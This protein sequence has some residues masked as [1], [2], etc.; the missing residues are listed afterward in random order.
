MST[1]YS[2]DQAQLRR[3]TESGIA[4][5]RALNERDEQELADLRTTR[6]EYA[7]EIAS[8]DDVMADLNDTISRRQSKMRGDLISQLPPTEGTVSSL[9]SS[10]PVASEVHAE[11][12]GGI[13][14]LTGEV[15]PSPAREAFADD[16]PHG[17]CINCGEPAWRVPISEASPKGATHSYGATCKPEDPDSGQADLGDLAVAP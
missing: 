12:Y 16:Q 4:R 6:A 10:P 11:R 7:A 14:P 3:L 15:V 13:P 2:A 5:Y 8:I 17:S 9:F 1:A